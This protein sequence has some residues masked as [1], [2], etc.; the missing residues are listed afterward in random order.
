M[1]TSD[2]GYIP[3]IAKIRTPEDSDV[4]AY[5]WPKPDLNRRHTDF[6]SVATTN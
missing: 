5:W 6:Q 2:I 4:V 3:K 1:H